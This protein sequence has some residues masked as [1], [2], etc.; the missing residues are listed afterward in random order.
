VI[1]HVP[2]EVSTEWQTRPRL[3][4][5]GVVPRRVGGERA[6]DC[7]GPAVYSCNSSMQ[8]QGAQQNSVAPCVPM[9]N[10]HREDAL[11]KTRFRRPSKRPGSAQTDHELQGVVLPHRVVAVRVA[12]VH[13]VVGR[14]VLDLEQP[15]AALSFWLKL[16]ALRG[17]KSTV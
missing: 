13:V 1:E 14:G 4:D 7:A 10:R 5:L 3:V 17:S 16:T 2:L 12:R 15:G 11:Q 9:Q 8:V 6:R